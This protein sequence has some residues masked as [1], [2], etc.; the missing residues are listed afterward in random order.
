MNCRV[1]DN[2]KKLFLFCKKYAYIICILSFATIVA[3]GGKVTIEKSFD[4]IVLN[5]VCT[6]NVKCCEDDKGNFPDWI[7]IYNPTSNDIDISGYIVNDSADLK[8]EKFVIPDGT[9][10][11]A[12]AYYL[13]DPIFEMS[14]EGCIVNLLDDRKNYVDRVEI[15]KLKYDTTYGRTEDGGDEWNIKSP[16]PGWSNGDG[17]N[18]QAIAEGRVDASSPSGFY[19]E[20]FDLSLRS[21]EIGRSIYYTTDGS[22]PVEN[23]VLYERPIRISDRSG[24][25]NIYSA[26]PE[27][28]LEYTEGRVSLPSYPV[29]KCTIV[30]TI[31]KDGLGKYT[32]ESIYSYFVGYDLKYG[33]DN[34]AVVS[35]VA[36]PFDLFS[37]ENGIMVL[38]DKYSQYV[39]EGHPEVYEGDKANFIPRGR[40]S[41]R[42]VHIE[43][44]DEEHRAVLEKNA[45]IRIKGMSSRWDVQKSFSIIFRTA[46]GGDYKE[47]FEVDNTLFDLHSFALDKCGQDTGTKMK[48]TIMEECMAQTDCATVKRVP[49][50]L[51]LNGEYWGFYW[52]SERFDNSYL[53]EKYGVDKEDVIYKNKADFGYGEWHQ[54]D[55][56]RQSLIDCYAA[57]IIAARGR[58][59]PS[60]N[61]RVW[62]TLSD[63]GT[64]FGDGKYRPVIFDV[65]S[66][67]MEDADF[68]LFRE[69]MENFYP[70]QEI[71]ADDEN[72]K[73]DL[74]RRI[75][76]MCNNEFE[77]NKILNM[78]DRIY[79]RIYDQMVLDNMRYTNC[80]REEAEESFEENVSALKNFFAHRYDN[81]K[82]FEERFLYE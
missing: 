16:T 14:S 25:Y 34:M 70:F 57:N 8:K 71:V 37:D 35:A 9:V 4:N 38:G 11:A 30:R 24:D 72:F 15:P 21:T 52:I 76:E 10:L 77:Q 20:D 73:E 40:R 19:N 7:E 69:M 63:E 59:W 27:V 49:C 58:G 46:Y 36:D 6:S 67:S 45:G 26:I 60:Y 55:F 68:D 66:A 12:G 74:V 47:A 33:Y 64:E 13:F 42:A 39:N 75:D 23:G 29:D 65:N 17:E 18:L 56:D 3:I 22:D 62:K 44:F 2:M 82:V 51:F 31:A 53:L 48:D 54:E 43:V 41:E 61:F 1:W 79:D 50:C 5:E 81:L 32:E 78:I 28:S 80:S